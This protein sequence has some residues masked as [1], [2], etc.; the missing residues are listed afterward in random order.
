MYTRN[1]LTALLLLFGIA[2]FAQQE[3]W[4]G[5]WACAP[6]T[7]DKRFMPYNNQMNNRAVRQIVKVSIGGKTIRLK[8]SNELSTTPVEIESVYIAQ[9]ENGSDIRKGKVGYLKFSGKD[10]VTLPAGKAIY[11]DELQFELQPLSKIA[12]TINYIK[13]PKQ[14]T[15]HMGSR[16]TSYILKGKANAD[17]SFRTAFKEEHW[18]NIAGIE[19]L[20]NTATAIAILGN[21]ITD[22]KAST[23]NAQNRWPDIFSATI[24]TPEK[25]ETGVLNLGIGDNRILSV[26]LGTPGK[27]RFDRDILGQHG[28]H[29]VIIFEAI[30]D[31]G[32]SKNPEETA[33]QLIEAYK[34]MTKKAHAHG[35]KVYMGTITPFE[36]CKSYYNEAREKARQTV[37]EWIRT[38]HETDGFI[39]FDELMRNPQHP[40]QLRKEWQS[41]DWLHPNPEGYKAM[42]E[43]AAK[44]L[45][46]ET[47]STTTL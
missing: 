12:I 47:N 39:D 37:N 6:Q 26:G 41:G 24:N 16:T 13:A 7:V 10:G 42:G 22:G 35:L 31:I 20:S 32:T 3:H 29:S 46:H 27:E 23:N 14:P 33:R 2:T 28:L 45:A 19:V 11:S 1:F 34:E 9:A 43:H 30:N 21:S 44:V 5:T 18:F 25:A 36:G 15:V 40:K 8:L 38:T 17:T 4:V